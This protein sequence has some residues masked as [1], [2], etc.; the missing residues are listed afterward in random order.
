MKLTYPVAVLYSLL[1]PHFSGR[2]G[3]LSFLGVSIAKRKTRAHTGVWSA[4]R[5]K[6]INPLKITLLPQFLHRIKAEMPGPDRGSY[7]YPCQVN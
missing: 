4:R 3:E 7:V 2:F 1:S 5:S 6:Q